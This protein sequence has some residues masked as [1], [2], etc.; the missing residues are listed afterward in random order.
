MDGPFKEISVHFTQALQAENGRLW[1]L[2]AS[3]S[4]PAQEAAPAGQARSA[5]EICEQYA[6]MCLHMQ[7][8]SSERADVA[9]RLSAAQV[10]PCAPTCRSCLALFALGNALRCPLRAKHIDRPPVRRKSSRF[11]PWRWMYNLSI[12]LHQLDRCCDKRSS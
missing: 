7:A 6:A 10:P 8:V 2:V 9:A 11:G 4:S 5:A 3:N 12:P 1:S